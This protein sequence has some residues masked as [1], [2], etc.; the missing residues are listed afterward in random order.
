MAMNDLD[1]VRLR[2]YVVAPDVTP[3]YRFTGTCEPFTV[4]YNIVR[5][6]ASKLMAAS[7]LPTGRASALISTGT[8]SNATPLW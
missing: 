2:V 4:Y 7:V 3:P 5:L 8:E 1:I 6:T